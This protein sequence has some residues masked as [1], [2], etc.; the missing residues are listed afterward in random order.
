MADYFLVH[1]PDVLDGQLR[2]ALAR[3]WRLRS[4]A[5]C[6]DFCTSCTAAAR[7]QAVRFH[8]PFDQTVLAHVADGLPFDRTLWRTLAG[9]LLL[10]AALDVPELPLPA[11]TLSCLLSGDHAPQ[12]PVDRA[13]FAPI[14]QALY[15]AR[16]L[17]FGPIAYRPD[18]AGLNARDD[19]ARLA[20]YLAGV[21]PDNWSARD[22][23]CLADLDEADRDD[24]LELAG[25][26]W[27]ALV[28]LYQRCVAAGYVL[29]LEQIF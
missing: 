26:W 21:R 13:L 14:H 25:E 27:P 18:Q 17:T 7:D 12:R 2:P 1:D 29:V 6:V 23:Y 20:A 8:L 22:L 24:E 28:D 16:E 11:A 5:P 4:F 19:V 9:E 15:G 10:F 3:T